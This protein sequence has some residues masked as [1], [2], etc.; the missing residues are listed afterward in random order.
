MR[1]RWSKT[2]VALH[3]LGAMIIAGLAAAGFVM[4]DLPADS[5]GRLLISRMH[6]LG[7]VTLMLLSVARLL[8]RRRGP[9]VTPL[10]VSE[11][12]RRGV[13]AIHALLYVVTFTIGLSGLVTGAR[14]AWPDYLRG[15][16]TEAPALEA[17]VTRQAHEVLVFALLGLVLL[18]VGGV[19]VQQVRRGGV[20]RRM[21]PFLK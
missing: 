6:T 20:L 8:F 2:S 9:A 15:Q 7:G 14:S 12:H 18:H 19:M 3:W 21:V 10:P 13:G 4:T 11:L 5:S 16:L 1:D 17:L